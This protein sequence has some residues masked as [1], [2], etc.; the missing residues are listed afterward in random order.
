MVQSRPLHME[1]DAADVV[2]YINHTTQ[3]KLFNKIRRALIFAVLTTI[4][5]ELNSIYHQLDIIVI[6]S[7]INISS[8]I[9]HGVIMGSYE[10]RHQLHVGYLLRSISRQS[11]LIIADACAHSVHTRDIGTETESML[12]L[13]V[14]TTT[15]VAILSLIPAWFLADSVQ[16][17]IKDMLLYSFTARYR[18]LHIPGLKG[19]TGLGVIVY[20]L[21]FVIVNIFDNPP[22]MVKNPKSTFFITLNRAASMIFSNQFLSRIIPESSQQILPVAILLGTY[23]LS[24]H[25]PMSSSVESYV[26]WQTAREVAEWISRV[27]PGGVTDQIIL[28]SILLC[29]LPV[30]NSKT[31]AVVAVAAMQTLVTHVMTSLTYLGP[32]S[33]AMASICILLATDIVLDSPQ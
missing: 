19:A 10:I 21:L 7:A 31:G 13:V 4:M 33:A 20:G 1:I 32:I 23:I 17:S 12:L 9:I 6:A 14:T 5:K 18:E 28:F 24:D 11:L 29:I 30:V 25:L 22:D 8:N 15:Y 26:L 16:G 27:F 3:S 2:K